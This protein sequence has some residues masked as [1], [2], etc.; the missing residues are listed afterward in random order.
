VECPRKVKN[1]FIRGGG[2][3]DSRMCWGVRYVWFDFEEKKK[4]RSIFVGRERKGIV[5]GGGG[6]V[7]ESIE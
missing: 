1:S 2:H 7:V 5:G 4:E 3:P 6:G